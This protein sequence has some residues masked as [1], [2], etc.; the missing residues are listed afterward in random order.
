MLITFKHKYYNITGFIQRFFILLTNVNIMSEKQVLL[1]FF[2]VY[3]SPWVHELFKSLSANSSPQFE[4]ET[5]VPATYN[6]YKI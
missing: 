3:T 4:G 1:N 2:H 5:I 6:G